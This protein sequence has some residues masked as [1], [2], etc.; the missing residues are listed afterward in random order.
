MDENKIL[1]IRGKIF[2][3]RYMSEQQRLADELFDG[4]LEPEKTYVITDNEVEMKK[5]RARG[6]LV[7]VQTLYICTLLE[8]PQ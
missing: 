6:F 3:K 2:L 4:T 1:D 8:E 5:L 7:E